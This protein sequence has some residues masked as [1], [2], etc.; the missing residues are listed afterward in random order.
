MKIRVE[1]L[2]NSIDGKTDMMVWRGM[3]LLKFIQIPG[4][5]TK[6]KKKEIEKVYK[7]TYKDAKWKSLE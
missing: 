3:T 6:E 1:F 4:T 7:K 2:H 5:L